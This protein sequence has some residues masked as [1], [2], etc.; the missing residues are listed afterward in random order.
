M[1][2]LISIYRYGFQLINSLKKCFFAKICPFNVNSIII[3][4]YYPGVFNWLF[5]YLYEIINNTY[6]VVSVHDI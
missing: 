1:V 6:S 3:I 4:D 2:K 5:L